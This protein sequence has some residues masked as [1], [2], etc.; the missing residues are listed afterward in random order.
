V[1]R[2]APAPLIRLA[3]VLALFGLVGAL[4][5]S[6]AGAEASQPGQARSEPG[7]GIEACGGQGCDADYC[8]APIESDMSGYAVPCP[9]RRG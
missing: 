7:Y 1:K 9:T 8:A 4:H 6:F 3:F 2:T 5:L